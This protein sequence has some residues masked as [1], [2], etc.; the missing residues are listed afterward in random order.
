MKKIKMNTDVDGQQCI[1]HFR[2]LLSQHRSTANLYNQVIDPYEHSGESLQFLFTR[3]KRIESFSGST[4]TCCIDSRGFWEPAILLLP[5]R[6]PVQIHAETEWHAPFR[7]PFL[8]GYGRRPRRRNVRP[9]AGER[10]SDSALTF[11]AG[12]RLSH[13]QMKVEQNISGGCFRIPNP[14]NH[15]ANGLGSHFFARLVNGRERH[16]Q[17]VGARST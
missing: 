15:G 10:L 1:F 8:D 7:Q 12:R 3:V 5:V 13:N 17:E 4:C 11:G 16:R 14:L 9:L 2:S 6:E